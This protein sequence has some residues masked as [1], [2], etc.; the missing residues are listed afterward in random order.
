MVYTSAP[1]LGY[2]HHREEIPSSGLTPPTIKVTDFE[3]AA[4]L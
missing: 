1:G 3:A 2:C 4:L